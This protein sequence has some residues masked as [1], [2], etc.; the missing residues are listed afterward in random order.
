MILECN[1][2]N[3]YFTS[4][5]KDPGLSG[6]IKSF[7]APKKS[8]YQ[9][10]KD[11]NLSI[12]EPEIMALLGPN[13]AGKTTLM[14]MFTGIIVPTSGELKVLGHKP[15]ERSHEFRKNIAIVMGQKSQLWWDLPA[16]DSL[17]LLKAYYEIEDEVFTKKVDYMSDFLGVRHKLKTHIRKLSL[18]ERMKLELM[19]CLIHSPKILFLDEPTIGLDLISQDNIRQFIKT[20]HREHNATIVVTSH[21]MADVQELCSR[22]VMIQAGMKSFDGPIEQFSN[23]LGREQIA[24]F[25]FASNFT[26]PDDWGID[27][28]LI[29]WDEA[30]KS[31]E[32][33]V[34]EKE[35]NQLAAYLLKNFP[36][37]KFYSDKT[38][39]EKIMKSILSQPKFKHDK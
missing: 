7:I 4:I 2:L 36:V 10:V 15:S 8:T 38:P 37:T 18:G 12:K 28:K 1:N 11:F 16:L 27:A 33:M 22:I 21:Y 13:G 39:I 26:A 30:N 25:S 17:H 24:S 14:K 6:T 9:A 34:D 19:A 31:L 29:N 20:Y 35:L 32:L 3:R 23:L 5:N